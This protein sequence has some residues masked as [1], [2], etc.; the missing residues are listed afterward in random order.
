METQ[1]G[2]NKDTSPFHRGE[3]ELHS[4]LGIQDR[5]DKLG[6]L[7]LRPY[8]PEQHQ[9]FFSQLPFLILGSVDPAGWPWTS[10]MFGRPG[11]LTSPTDKKLRVMANPVQ[12][13]PIKE[14]MKDN[15]P[16]SVLGIELPTRRRNRMNGIASR[17]SAGIYDIDVVQSFGNCP[18]YIQTRAPE[19]IRDPGAESE[20]EVKHFSGLDNKLKA[21]IRASDT[22]FVASFNADDDIRDTGGVDVNHRGGKPGFIHIDG[23]TL[24]IPDY[25]GNNSFNTL[26][27]FLVNPKAG[28][29]FIDFQTGDL[30]MMVGNVNVLWEKT[31]QIEAMPGAQRAWTF[32]LDHGV[33]IKNGSPLRWSFGE[34]SPK[35]P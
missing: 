32:T 17:K 14:N 19:F 22:F 8:M 34:Y 30:V 12:G 16:V 2:W 28:L 18:Q 15:A 23:D 20:T 10:I 33:I 29:L 4:R 3:R 35:L 24:T 11:F 26:G 6:R 1:T 25:K 9:E 21:F 7:I 31:P 27:N 13:D 5:Q